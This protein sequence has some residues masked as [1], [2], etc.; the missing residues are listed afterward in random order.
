M[1]EELEVATMEVAAESLSQRLRNH[2]GDSTLLKGWEVDKR[3][4]V[5][6]KR[7]SLRKAAREAKRLATVGP[8]EKRQR[9]VEVLL[10]ELAKAGE[11]DFDGLLSE[12]LAAFAAP[13]V[14]PATASAK[15]DTVIQAA[16]KHL[17]RGDVKKEKRDY[18]TAEGLAEKTRAAARDYVAAM[19]H[20]DQMKAAYAM[21]VDSLRDE[22]EAIGEGDF[23]G[24]LRQAVSTL[25]TGACSAAAVDVSMELPDV[26]LT[27]STA[28]LRVVKPRDGDSSERMS[29]KTAPPALK[30][31]ATTADTLPPKKL[32]MKLEVAE[33]EA[34]C[35]WLGTLP[36]DVQR[37]LLREAFVQGATGV[38]GGLVEPNER[39]RGAHG[40]Y[41]EPVGV[42]SVNW[43]GLGLHGSHLVPYE[44][45][46]IAGSAA[47]DVLGA[48]RGVASELPEA[49]RA[50][51]DSF[52]PTSARVAFE[53]MGGRSIN[54]KN[55]SLCGWSTDRLRTNTDGGLKILVLLGSSDVKESFKYTKRDQE[56]LD[57]TLSPGD[58]LLLHDDARAWVS[59]V[60]G[61][62]PRKADGTTCPF[63]FVHLSLLDLR[64]YKKAK[65]NE[66]ARLMSPERPTP[67]DGSYKWMQCRYLVTRAA[68]AAEGEAPEIELSSNGA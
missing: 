55:G 34:G 1:Q 5:G 57:L 20:A 9:A 3:T 13:A 41:Y 24:L 16:E 30:A 40:A 35:V 38:C 33:I 22:L 58:V 56:A 64:A 63:D 23:D 15:V 54:G 65:P 62:T 45:L 29:K 6:A 47:A 18:S 67:R 48:I 60:T 14:A 21:Q 27:V 25:K 28:G 61:V 19:A 59:A 49:T 50:R 10:T 46:P 11:A 31:P 52:V 68:A 36:S 66:H 53:T 7:A 17:Q 39:V 37:A 43:S 2:L 42:Q 12:A 51:L 44:Q 4:C 26:P 32:S 8:F